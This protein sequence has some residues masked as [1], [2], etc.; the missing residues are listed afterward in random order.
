M[1][2]PSKMQIFIPLIGFLLANLVLYAIYRTWSPRIPVPVCKRE[3]HEGWG[4]VK[5]ILID[6]LRGRGILGHRKW[7]RLNPT[8]D[9]TSQ[10]AIGL[11][12]R[13]TRPLPGH[14][15]PESWRASAIGLLLL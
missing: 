7:G 8:S 10:I 15:Q 14:I 6:N 12:S 1:D 9:K 3:N 2:V 5:V 4:G 13:A 11:P